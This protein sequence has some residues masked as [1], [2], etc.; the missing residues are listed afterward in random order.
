MKQIKREIIL[1]ATDAKFL[2]NAPTQN[3]PPDSRL[4]QTPP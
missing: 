3:R 4:R 1:T 2:P